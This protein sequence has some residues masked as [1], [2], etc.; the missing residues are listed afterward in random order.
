M[1]FSNA[2]GTPDP[3]EMRRRVTEVLSAAGTPTVSVPDLEARLQATR[4]R[5]DRLVNALAAGAEDLP[6]V[7]G[8]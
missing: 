4:R 7:R 8:P 5:V 2:S 6:S 1:G 3:A